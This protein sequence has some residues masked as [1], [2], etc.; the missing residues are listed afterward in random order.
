MKTLLRMAAG[1]GAVAMMSLSPVLAAESL[2][3]YQ[4]TD[5]KMDYALALCG[6]GEKE[7]CVTLLAAR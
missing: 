5:R 1:L 3:V 6:K 7:L 2:G 4:T